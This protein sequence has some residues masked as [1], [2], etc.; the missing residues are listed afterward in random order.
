MFLN[1]LKQFN[2][3]DIFI[4]ILLIRICYV[5]LKNGFSVELFKLF[6]LLFAAYVSMHYYS[7]FSG[8]LRKGFLFKNLSY[9]TIRFF[10]FFA[11]AVSGNFIF[12]ILRGIFCRFIKMEAAPALNK[13]GGFILGIARATL[14]LSL[15]IFI[16]IISPVGYA[17]YSV[18]NSY[19]A[20]Y[21]FNAAPA[22]Y[23]TLWYAVASKFMVNEE[24]NE[25]ISAV[26]DDIGRQ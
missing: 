3:L 18:R 8:F 17:R 5:A 26:K 11:L 20:K 16:L 9:K 24:F 12:I 25:D 7:V 23:S 4:L 10:S 21:F 1:M 15:I 14:L 13:W 22:V 2:W 19:S 6:G